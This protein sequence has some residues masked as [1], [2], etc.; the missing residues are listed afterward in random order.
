MA[1]IGK[2]WA[3]RVFG[4]NT[5][6]VF[7]EINPSNGGV[8]GTIRFSDSVF[9]LVIYEFK[10]SFDGSTLELE[11]D[12][13]QTEPGV[14]TGQLT[15]KAVLTSQ[16]RF[17][18]QWWT[19]LGTAGTLELFPHDALPADQ[20]K[21]TDVQ[22]PEQLRTV[23]QSFGAV[24]LYWEDIQELVKVVKQDF[25]VGRVI[26]SYKLN[27]D[28]I[29]QYFEDFEKQRTNFK[30]CKYL[31]LSIQEPEAHGINRLAVIELDSQGRNDLI[32]QGIHESMGRGKG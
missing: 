32:V 29:T 24:R 21:L 25:V 3:G 6:N 2:L 7:V 10:G 20:S 30:E 14:E 11:G 13:K 5:G 27:G 17:H 8:I 19:S 31:K 9:G 26:V 1:E 4:T 23:R 15:A 12:S 22:I 16:G 18:G 28:E